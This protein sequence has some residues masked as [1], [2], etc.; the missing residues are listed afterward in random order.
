MKQRLIY[1]LIALTWGFVLH[2]PAL[3]NFGKAIP[4]SDQGDTIRGHWSAWLFSQDL[5]SLDTTVCLWPDG[6]HVL[7]LPPFS[8]ALLSPVTLLFGAAISLSIFL[9]A[10]TLL[11]VV[12]GYFLCRTLDLEK[13]ISLCLGLLLSATPMLGET[14]NSGVYEYQTLGWSTLCFASLI[15]ACKGNWKWGFLAGFFYILTALECGYYGSSAALGCILIPCV[16]IRSKRGIFGGL[17]A[18]LT[19]IVLAWLSYQTLQNTL[20]KLLS[21]D[22]QVGGDF[23]VIMG[24]A[25]ILALLPG[26]D[27]PPPPPGMPDPFVSAPHLL[28]WL[29]FAFSAV[30]TVRKNWWMSLLALLYLSIAMQSPLTDWWTD[31][32]LGSFVQNL[33]RYAAPMNLMLLLTIGFGLQ[34]ILDHK[35]L[36]L[37]RNKLLWILTGVLITLSAKDLL[38]RYPLLWTPKV[39]LFAQTI[40]MDS[41]PG[42]V[43]VFPQEKET[44]K[45]TGHQYLRKNTQFSNP[46]IRLWFQ[47]LID[48]PMR[49]HSKLATLVAKPGRRWK[50]DGGSLDRQ[51][52]IQLKQAGLRYLIIDRSQLSQRKYE[53][54][55]KTVSQQGFGCSYFDEWGGIDLCLIAER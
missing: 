37:H 53:Q 11:T 1:P 52:L 45:S 18:A 2:R 27:P 39:P 55:K 54:T 16:Y 31:G 7:P 8:F 43:I 47:T 4:G 5:W 14:L 33:R 30:I 21:P 36:P 3:L 25:E 46:Q 32:P 51:E 13:D 34:H 49:H 50:I 10:H 40:T 42:A 23:R 6:A 48:R 9:L 29:L 41:T 35:K 15:R 38:L 19:T 12:G 20:S 17:T 26:I 24:S 28:I 22:L 44:R